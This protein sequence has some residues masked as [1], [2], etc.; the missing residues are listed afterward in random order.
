MVSFPSCYRLAA[1]LSLKELAIHAPTAF[2]SKTSQSTLGQGG[3]NEF[4]DNIFQAIR[5]PHPIVRACAADALSQCLKIL[6]ERRHPS[7]T[8]LLCQVH[9]SLTEGL[10]QDTLRKRPWAAI[11]Q[12]DGIQHGSLLVVSCLIAYTGDFMLPRFDEVCTAVL[13]F[14]ENPEPLI[15]LEVVRLIPRLARRCPGIFSRRYLD[16][17]LD[18]LIESASTQT[19]PR[20][21]VDIRPTAYTAIGQLIL[22]MTDENSGLVTGGLRLPTVKIRNDPNMPD[23]GFTVKLSETGVIYDKLEEIFS[24]VRGGLQSGPDSVTLGPALK[25]AANLVQAL[26][27]MAVPYIPDLIND[28]FRAGLT[29]DL[30]GALHAIAQCVP[31]QQRLIENRLLQ[32]TSIVLAGMSS[33]K[34]I[35]DPLGSFRW[36]PGASSENKRT[37]PATRRGFAPA[38]AATHNRRIT[39]NMS[40]QPQDVRALVLSLH[41]LGTF[42]D[43]M[44]RVITSGAIVPLL[45][46]VRDVAIKYL[47]HPA[48]EVRKAAALTSLA[49]LIPE[50]CVHRTSFSGVV[51][52]ECLSELLRMAII[53]PS[54]VVRLCVVKALDS[55]YNPY[56]CQAHHLQSLFLLLSDEALAT[57]AAGVQL[58]GRLTLINPAPILPVLRKFL[59]NLIVELQCGVDTGRGRE[60]ATRILV[61]FLR[62]E[63]LQRLVHPV[64]HSVVTALPLNGAAPRLASAALEALGELAKATGPD[65]KP[66]VREVVPHVLNT[67]QDQSSASKQ[68]ISLMTL[69]QIAGSTGYVIRPYLDYP[70][71]LSQATDV[72]PGTKRAPWSLRREVI[73]CLGVLGALDPDRYQ[74][75]ESK[76]RKGGAVGGAYFEE[77]DELDLSGKEAFTDDSPEPTAAIIS[78]RGALSKEQDFNSLNKAFDNDDDLPAHLSMYEQYA[79]VV[80]PVS[81]LPPARRISPSDEMFYPTVAI[82]ALM[83]IFRDT[84]LAVHHGMVIQ[85]IMFIF[86]SMGLRCVPFLKKVVPHMIYSVRTCNV[87]NLR[88]SLLQQ[89]ASLSEI[90]REHLRPF[91]A[92]IFDVVEQFWSSRHLATIFLLVSKVA[93]AVPDEFRRFVPRLMR[94]LLT[95][96]DELQVA[97]W[98]TA[99]INNTSL[100]GNMESEKLGL[101]LRSINSL[102][103][104]LGG[105]LHMLVPAL[106][107]L[108]DSLTSLSAAVSS[109]VH[110]S[111]FIDLHVLSLR[112]TAALIECQD[113]AD[114]TQQSAPLWETE[115]RI[116]TGSDCS[117]SARAVQPLVRLLRCRPPICRDVGL[118]AIET[119]C[120]CSKSIG[121]TRWMQSYHRVVKVCITEWDKA[122]AELSLHT[123]LIVNG[124]PAA[125]LSADDEL[126]GLAYYNRAVVDLIHKPSHETLAYDPMTK[127][128]SL[129][130]LDARQLSFAEAPAVGG[131]VDGGIDFDQNA[132]TVFQPS[133]QATRQRVNQGNLQRSWDITQIA[134]RDDW[135][136]WMRSLSIQLLKEAPSPA[137]RA[138]AQL[139]HAYQVC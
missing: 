128:N 1:S 124:A 11:A 108:S 16:Q 65:L 106:L 82:Q 71:L 43:P 36:P 104:V 29:H 46:F 102:R 132:A 72:L 57:R 64:L 18:F 76:T 97:E 17:G 100:V 99:E 39:I 59:V 81:S 38:N 66:W 15:R 58:L 95:S 136:Q 55:R 45:P 70:E 121:G 32:T 110:Q 56:L 54:G 4:I 105:Y 53:D 98:S 31:E 14:T 12:T 113:A 80:Q 10:E 69:G 30:I 114:N 96:L 63:S 7:L 26:N 103:T 68:R 127:T 22:S 8:G 35:C 33:A 134:S 139:A 123:L 79:M 83:R 34:D 75:V 51:I 21:S 50:G 125:P 67:M 13:A 133:G 77:Q 62:A 119:L 94:R 48:T 89:L 135:D 24:L 90:V 116:S 47:V 28:M 5:D 41:T 85:A 93:V 52:E 129:L 91:I 126:A 44:G 74:V 9:F 137:L 138:T 78:E 92:D 40:E 73:R 107:K 112:T 20:V 60:E 118:A 23:R 122:S 25:C 37:V 87:V 115:L 2:H 109:E 84:S 131:V 6:V 61:V 42:G 86:K 88:E 111:A 101:I 19:A 49:L 3:S 130:V 117:L 27:T 120:A